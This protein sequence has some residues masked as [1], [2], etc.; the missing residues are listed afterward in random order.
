MDRK[1]FIENCY[2][3][4]WLTAREKRYGF[5]EYDKNLCNYI[6]NFYLGEG[7]YWKLP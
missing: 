4:Y 6:I 1:T 7:K 3:S 2:S 5:M